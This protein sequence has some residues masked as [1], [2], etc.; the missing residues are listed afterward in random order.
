[1]STEVIET[2]L[3]V[4]STQSGGNVGG[5]KYFF[6]F[7]DQHI[8]VPHR[9]TVSGGSAGIIMKFKLS[10]ETL[11]NFVVTGLV[12]S[13]SQG[14]LVIDGPIY[15]PP[16]KKMREVEVVNRATTAC[17]FNIGIMVTDTST[18][19]YTTICCDPQVINTPDEGDNA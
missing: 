11:D 15:F 5:G 6:A 13:D 17:L 4:A 9:K 3:S 1:M 7:S 19:P 2:K 12:A 10:K 16:D 8:Y 18:T 14:N